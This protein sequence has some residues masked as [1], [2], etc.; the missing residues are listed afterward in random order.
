MPS[1]RGVLATA[2]AGLVALA[3]C[4]GDN[5]VETPDDT[6]TTRRTTG[7]TPE[8]TR[9]TSDRSEDEAKYDRVVLENRT[10]EEHVA[11]VRVERD[12]DVPHEAAYRVPA[13]T[14]LRVQR[15]FDWGTHAVSASVDD[16]DRRGHE[17]DHGSCA[18]TPHPSGNQNLGVVVESEGWS[19]V[20]NACDYLGVGETYVEY[21]PASEY[22][23]ESTATT[24]TTQ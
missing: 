1:R 16:G 17:W 18:N 9:T 3:G 10:D 21:G 14:G 15:E 19:F 20:A 7:P 2:G 13:N 11:W 24:T 22:E 8:T 4:T 5:T 6:Q 23:V 12:G